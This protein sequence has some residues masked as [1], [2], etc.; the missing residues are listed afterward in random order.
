MKILAEM[1]SLAYST[2]DL[3]RLC[4]GLLDCEG[5]G[6]ITLEKFV[7]YAQNEL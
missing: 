1:A 3:L 4:A 5:F 6:E 2:I 7:C